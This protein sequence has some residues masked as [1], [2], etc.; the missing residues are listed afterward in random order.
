MARCTAASAINCSV[1]NTGIARR[2]AVTSNRSLIWVRPPGPP[3]W[4][5]PKLIKYHG[6]AGGKTNVLPVTAAITTT[7]SRTS[8]ILLRPPWSISKVTY[9]CG[10]CRGRYWRHRF[11][12]QYFRDG[13]ML[14]SVNDGTGDYAR[15]R[16]YS[17]PR[18]ED[19]RLSLALPV[20][21]A[22]GSGPPLGRTP[23]PSQSVSIRLDLNNHLL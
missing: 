1:V 20:L 10:F 23:R 21:R 18:A 19:E 11:S 13:R 5:G 3:P 2:K 7:Y 16:D 12:S 6:F 4:I 15:T 8:R 17:R 14:D 9:R 22:V